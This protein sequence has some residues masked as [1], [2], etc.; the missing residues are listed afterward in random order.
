MGIAYLVSVLLFW[1]FHDL[2]RLLEFE[3]AIYAVLEH[4]FCSLPGTAGNRFIWVRP[5]LFDSFSFLF[6]SFLELRFIIFSMAVS[7][8]LQAV[9]ILLMLPPGNNKKPLLLFF[10]PFLVGFLLEFIF[11]ISGHMIK[12]R[13]SFGGST[14]ISIS[15]SKIMKKISNRWGSSLR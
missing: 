4:L 1:Q 7:L 2:I 9:S 3:S 6:F 13:S 12:R 8:F 5:L 14:Q 10:P 15:V 11:S